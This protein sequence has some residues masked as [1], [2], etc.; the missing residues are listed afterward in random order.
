[1]T[2]FSAI[3]FSVFTSA[4]FFI[5]GQFFA[6]SGTTDL[7]NY[8]SNVPYICIL[9]VPALCYKKSI[10]IYDDFIPVSRG[11]KL[12]KNFLK[13]FIRFALLILMMLPVC[14]LVNLFGSVDAGQI[15]TGLLCL[16][17]Y[18]ASLIS[19]CLFINEIFSNSIISF[20]ASALCLAVFNSIHIVPLYVNTNSFFT[21]FCKQFSFAWHFDAASK[22][23]IDTRDF[24]WLLLCTIFF[25]FSTWRLIM[26]KKGKVF[27]RKKS[28]VY[29]EIFG[30]LLLILLNSQNY[31]RRFDFSKTKSYSVS[32]YTKTLADNLEDNLKITYYRSG[33]LAKLYPQ[34]RDV[35]DFLTSYT[36]LDKK[37]SYTIKDPDKDEQIRTMLENY[38]VTSQQIQNVGATTTSYSSVYSAI[39]LEYRGMTQIIPFIMSSQTLEYDMDMRIKNLIQA[40]NLVVNIVVGNG[41]SLDEDYSYI[42][43]W[44]NSQGILAN[45]LYIED[46]SFAANLSLATGPLLVIGDSEINIDNAIAIEN[47]ILEQKGNAVFTVSPYSCSIEED[48]SITS[49][50]K[51]NIVEMLENWGV[52]FT[53][54]IAADISCARIT[55]TSDDDYTEVLNYP[56]WISLLPQQYCKLGMTL[57]W[58]VSLELS[59]NAM[60]YLVTSPSGFTYKTDR[61]SPKRLIESNPF[62]VTPESAADKQKSTLIIGAQI[63]GALS[64]LYNF[65]S[66][67]DSNIIV[68]SD[69]YFLNTLMTGYIGGDFGD[70]RNFEFISNCLLN[71]AGEGELAELQSKTTRDTSLYKVTDIQQFL[72]LRLLVFIILFA[73][74]PLIEVLCWWLSKKEWLRLAKPKL[75]GIPEGVFGNHHISIILIILIIFFTITSLLYFTVFSKTGEKKRHQ[76]EIQLLHEADISQIDGII[77]QGGNEGLIFTRKNNMWL[78]ANLDDPENT[79]PAD[80][81]RLAQLFVNLA[82]KH[83]MT[84]SGKK[85]SETTNAY[86]LDQTKGMVISIFKDG[87]E[88]QRLYF[89]STDFSQSRRYFTTLELNSIFLFDSSFENFLNTSVQSWSDPYIISQQLKDE[90]FQMGDAQGVSGVPEP[91]EGQIDLKKLLELRHGGIAESGLQMLEPELSFTIQMGDKSTINLEISEILTNA[92]SAKEYAVKTTFDSP[93]LSKSFTYTTKI[94]LW[95]YNKI[96]EIML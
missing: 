70:Y 28:F 71:L 8:F 51:T 47:Y 36:L 88:Y 3:L 83:V 39:V 20:V 75:N 81:N 49:N 62:Y 95:T 41:M 31:F 68:I 91:V 33:T 57:F 58:P 38:G 93:R 32:S 10:S 89:G 78:L 42:I 4:M 17:F 90:V 72:K 2:L 54:T 67:S 40:K 22:G 9:V 46:P 1:M 77:I 80:T 35:S 79:I 45:P 69:Q 25:L 60:P 92:D 11:K 21:Y 14:L 61:A 84:K 52:R 96:K 6:G 66:C 5:K 7:I 82:S 56:L 30:L 44:L 19:L 86:G 29:S 55:M 87:T 94:S 34:I 24:L 43:P 37:I 59:Q 76:Q 12:L 18:G 26:H 13:I 53:D 23:I 27:S 63:T 16:L 74:I 65:N 50:Y 73:V 48:W 64:G 15:F 85:D